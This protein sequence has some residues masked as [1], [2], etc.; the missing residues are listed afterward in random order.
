MR[1]ANL[2]ERV[3]NHVVVYVKLVASEVH[4]KDKAQRQ[5]QYPFEGV[6]RKVHKLE[7]GG[8]GH[9][10][11]GDFVGLVYESV[12]LCLVFVVPFEPPQTLSADQQTEPA[13]EHQ[14]YGHVTVEDEETCEACA[15][16]PPINAVC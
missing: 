1:A 2:S 9:I 3:L 4:V 12:H 13:K 10:H 14:Y 15:F 6:R 8:E 7:N 11:Y 16:K 5:R